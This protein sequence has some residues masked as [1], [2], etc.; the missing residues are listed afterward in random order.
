MKTT[1]EK[2]PRN[3]GVMLNNFFCQKGISVGGEKSDGLRCGI[4]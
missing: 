2:L 1:A 4:E 3:Y